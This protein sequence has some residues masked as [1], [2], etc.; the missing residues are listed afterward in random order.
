MLTHRGGAEKEQYRDRSAEYVRVKGIMNSV[1]RRGKSQPTRR[2]FTDNPHVRTAPALATI[3]G[4]ADI[5]KTPHDFT[6]KES[7]GVE[8]VPGVGFEPT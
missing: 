1:A 5:K 4:L 2:K 6:Q 7:W 3:Q 8:F